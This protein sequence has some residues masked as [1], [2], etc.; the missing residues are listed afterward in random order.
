M[1]NILFIFEGERTEKQI[2]DN[3]TKYFI[4]EKS[5]LIML[6]ILKLNNSF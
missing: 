2:T 3:L 4:S 1:A 6:I 5:L